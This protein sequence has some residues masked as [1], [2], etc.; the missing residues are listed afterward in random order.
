MYNLN[1]EKGTKNQVTTLHKSDGI[2]P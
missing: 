1:F 2:F